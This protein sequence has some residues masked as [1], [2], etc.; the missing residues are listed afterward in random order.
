MRA[1]AILS[2]SI[3]S[4]SFITS[5]VA[6]HAESPIPQAGDSSG[7]WCSFTG[8]VSGKWRAKDGSIVPMVLFDAK[9]DE[10]IATARVRSVKGQKALGQYRFR[11]VAAGKIYVIRPQWEPYSRGLKFTCRAG[12]HHE[13]PLVLKITKGPRSD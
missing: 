9:S 7:K 3:L 11:D 8:R 2:A 6:A 10:F 1:R 5:H 13:S 12:N 4:A